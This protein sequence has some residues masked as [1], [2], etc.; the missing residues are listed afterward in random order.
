VDILNDRIGVTFIDVQAGTNE[1]IQR[2]V[3][4][5]IELEIDQLAHGEFD[6]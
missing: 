3:S 2:L 6:P 4:R 5:A 1:L